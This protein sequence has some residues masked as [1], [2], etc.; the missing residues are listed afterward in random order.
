MSDD[1][2]HDEHDQVVDDT[3]VD[4]PAGL[5]A[6]PAGQSGLFLAFSDAFAGA[7][8]TLLLAA[9]VLAYLLPE[10]AFLSLEAPALRYGAAS[11]VAFLPIFLA[12]LV[13]AGSFKQ[14]GRQADVAF[15]SNLLGIMVGGM[16][17]YAA[18]VWG[19]RHLLLLAILFYALSAATRDVSA[20]RRLVPGLRTR[21][22]LATTGCTP[23]SPRCGVA[24]I[25]AKV[26]SI[27]RDGSERNDATPARVLSGSA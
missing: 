18:L 2:Q 20:L 17:E 8:S 21:A 3:T 25:A 10:D 23:A 12:N 26:C 6:Y 15:A 7:D 27:V 11:L 24:I 5:K 16:M 14:T 1:P 19:Y 9:L 13:F 22:A 4:L